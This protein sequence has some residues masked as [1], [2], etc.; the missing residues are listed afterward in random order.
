M[1]LQRLAQVHYYHVRLFQAL[2]T[3]IQNDR[4]H[5]GYLLLLIV[6]SMQNLCKTKQARLKNASMKHGH[7]LQS[8]PAPW[9]RSSYFQISSHGS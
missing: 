7:G 1:G 4:I 6:R 8:S 5:E 2:N 9:W 3:R